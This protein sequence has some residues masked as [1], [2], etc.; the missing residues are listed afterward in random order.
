MHFKFIFGPKTPQ[1]LFVSNANF[2]QDKKYMSVVLYIFFQILNLISEILFC[3]LSNYGFLT[4]TEQRKY[5][6]LNGKLKSS[7]FLAFNFSIIQMTKMLCLLSRYILDF[8][9]NIKSQLF[10]Y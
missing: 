10:F 5:L 9:L 3:S 8:V 1:H 2:H 4:K 6:L 7:I